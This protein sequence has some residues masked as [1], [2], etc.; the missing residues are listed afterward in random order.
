MKFPKY[1]YQKVSGNGFYRMVL[2][3]LLVFLVPF[4]LVS[5][6]WYKTS[7]N[8]IQQQIQLSSKN[9]LLQAKAA[10]EEQ[11]MQ[12]DDL[13]HQIPYES[14][15]SNDRVY[16]PYYGFL[17]TEELQ[18]FR[19]NS[20]FVQQI[21]LYYEKT[22]EKLFSTDG[23]IS[24][25]NF[26][27]R[28]GLRTSD[29][30][31]FIQRLKK[32]EN[33][34]FKLEKGNYPGLVAYQ[35]PLMNSEGLKYGT[36]VY[37]LKESALVD[38]FK[39]AVAMA[40][41]NFLV[42][43]SDNQVLLHAYNNPLYQA[44]QAKKVL[45]ELKKNQ[46]IKLDRQKILVEQMKNQ[47][48]NLDYLVLTSPQNALRPINRMQKSF[49]LTVL[50]ILLAGLL[51]VFLVGKKNY[52]PIENLL[53]SVKGYLETE[54][55]SKIANLK[56]VQTHIT[57]FL[58]E[59]KA[60][61][62]EIKLQTPH[63]REQLLRKLVNGRLKNDEEIRLLLSSVDVTYPKGKYFV[64]VI[65]VKA[66]DQ[67]LRGEVQEIL[68][69]NFSTIMGKIFVGYGTELIS[70]QELALIIGFEE[71]ISQQQV[72]ETV[73]LELQNT[74]G[75]ALAMGVGSEV[76]S[77]SKLNNS[78]IEALA[79]LDGRALMP[80]KDIFY[81]KEMGES[82]T[83]N[84]FQFPSDRQL[85]LIQS[86]HQ[87]DFEIA[88][89]TIQ[90][91]IHN[92][93]KVSPSIRMQKMY[94]YFLLNTV[95]KVGIELVGKKFALQADASGDFKNLRELEGDLLHL[96]QLICDFV[97][98]KS[99]N[100]ES[101][102]KQDLFTYLND[103]FT[104]YQLTIESLAEKFDLTVSYVSRFIKKETGTTF[105]KYVQ[106][107]RMEKVKKDL[108]ETDL[109]IKDIIQNCGYYD[110]SNFTR[111]FRTLVGVTPGKYRTL[112]K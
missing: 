17:A 103:N 3:Y 5:T 85:K 35:V 58:S 22:P 82:N 18:K 28:E 57:S 70:A 27:T 10:F 110:V 62:E 73:H 43:G 53:N 33:Q 37:T 65:D 34:L 51:V 54:D 111:K 105:S 13:S 93:I 78:Y 107:L 84:E 68:V 99:Q 6:I 29:K 16:H 24:L 108:V 39:K 2:S 90:W 81:Y 75:Y 60:L 49:L 83:I 69:S 11:L 48:L 66:I 106:D 12:L 38:I 20:N 45:P 98:E 7:G 67:K 77:L 21:Y 61:H 104:S 42:L 30:Q 63:A 91:L 80:E 32:G 102:L 112:N 89:E 94:G 41:D 74:F 86:L 26:A 19:G 50:L 55:N 95:T 15:L 1:P 52:Q 97:S 56:D 47:T 40:E 92:G 23:I 8:S 87:G 79:A 64:L 101:E 71:K 44:I 4:V 72:V 96:A 76:L 59:N 109:P 46:E 36:V 9:Q 14:S 88:E 31:Q 100:Q 25:D